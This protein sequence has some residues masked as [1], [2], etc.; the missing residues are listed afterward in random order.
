MK[1]DI[2]K[3]NLDIAKQVN[4]FT[5]QVS[6]GALLCKSGVDAYLKRNLEALRASITCIND[7]ERQ[8]DALR[9][10]IE[11]DIHKDNLMPGFR[12]DVVQLLEGMDLLLNQF[13]DL[14]TR[15]DI[16]SPELGEGLHADFRKLLDYSVEAVEADVR[17]CRAFFGNIQS[18]SDHIH[19]VN[20]WK[21]EAREVSARFQKNVFAQDS[22]TLGQKMHL[23][24]FA[25][26]IDQIADDSEAVADRLRIYVSKRNS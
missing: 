14:I 18:F 11:Q 12:S 5:E 26:Q 19:K 8:G 10:S 24:S 15:L 2:L 6:E 22:L 1:F 13:K 21:R 9:R 23:R 16:E 3:G 20:F 17:S 7:T 25:K 4:R